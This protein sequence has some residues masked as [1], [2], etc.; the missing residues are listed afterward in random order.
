MSSKL[1]AVLACVILVSVILAGCGSDSDPSGPQDNDPNVSITYPPDGSVIGSTVEVVAN[2]TDSRSVAV[3]E[4]YVDGALALSDSTSPY[5]YVWDAVCTLMGSAHSIHAVAYDNASNPATSDTITVHSRW[6]TIIT[7]GDEVRDCNVKSVAV[8]STETSLEFRVEMYEGWPG[9]YTGVDGAHFGLFLD[10]DCD[11]LTGM[12][13]A[14]GLHYAPN[15]IGADYFA[16]VGYEGDFVATWNDS[17]YWELDGVY[18]YLS[19][20]DNSYYFEAGVAL[21]DLSWPSAIDIVAVNISSFWDW[22]PDTGHA[23]YEVT[24]DYIEGTTRRTVAS[25]AAP[26]PNDGRPKP[27]STGKKE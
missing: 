9:S 20:S 17:I 26:S 14:T 12:S 4:F 1:T 2:A 24:G 16:S 25:T 19:I 18:E 10:T 21:E 15:D 5:T 23:R 3:V 7:D 6:R 22:A 8:R 13:E 11:V 27:L